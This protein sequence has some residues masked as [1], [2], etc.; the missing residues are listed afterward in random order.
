MK[1]F[2]LVAVLVVAL[3]SG[4]WSCRYRYDSVKIGQLTGL[5]R[6]NR[7]TGESQ[8]LWGGLGWRP[9]N[10]PRWQIDKELDADAPPPSPVAR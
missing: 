8:I 7:F 5:V 1:S 6:T 9:A 2:G 3:G 10:T 4:G